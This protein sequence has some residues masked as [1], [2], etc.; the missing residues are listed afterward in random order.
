MVLTQD[1]LQSII[2]ARLRAPHQFLGMHHLGDGSGVVVRAYLPN[3]AKVEVH[4][5]HEKNKPRIEMQQLDASGL[6][7]GVSTATKSIY[8][9]DLVITDYQGNVRRV[10]DAYSFL[11]TL[12]ETDLFLFGKGDEHRI[13]DKLGAQLRVIDGVPGTSFA[14]WAPNAQR[15][16][17][18]G[19][20]N[21]WD[22]RYH[23]MRSLG[24]SGVWELFVPGIGEGT[25]YKYEL[26][27]FHGK[28]VLKTDPYGFFFESAPKNASIVWNNRK[29]AWTDQAWL[30]QRGERN[31]L[32]SPV[33][34]YEVH[35]G[36]W[37]KKSA[38]ESFSYRELAGLLVPY[39]KQMGFTHVELMP[40]SEHAY[41]P[42]WGYQVTGFYSPTNRYGTPDDFQFLVNALHEAGIGVI[43]DWVPAHF[44]RD[45][46]ALAKFDGTSLYE[47]EDPR[48]GAHQD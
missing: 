32:R 33:S 41:F 5:T 13:Y 4:P 38:A 40:V 20:F 11:P 9:Y 36:S 39:L 29:F 8:A 12:G 15:V 17:V 18:V 23:T 46:W 35:L 16:S 3:A 42:S 19:T 14:V 6:Y 1:E 7:E 26:R 22:G 34:I 47:H 28:V 44:P 43:M 30:K 25:L 2:H 48:R 37:R 21:H 45:D 27:D 31:P 24:A 10:R